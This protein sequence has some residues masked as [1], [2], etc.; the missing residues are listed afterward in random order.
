M[1]RR[2]S[3]RLRSPRLVYLNIATTTIA[4][5]NNPSNTFN[6]HAEPCRWLTYLIINVKTNTVIYPLSNSPPLFNRESTSFVSLL[7]RFFPSYSIR[8]PLVRQK[9]IYIVLSVS[10]LIFSVGCHKKNVFDSMFGNYFKYRTR[11]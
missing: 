8:R 1:Q 4:N 11:S 5:S 2:S 7:V 3:P 6:F 9:L 10:R